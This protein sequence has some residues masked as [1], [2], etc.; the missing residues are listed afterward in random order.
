MRMWSRIQSW[1]RTVV[2]RSRMEREMDAELRFHI[3]TFAEDLV[4]NGVAREEALRRARIE[5][6]GIERAK[7]EC[8]EARGVSFFDSL[9]LDLRF[10]LRMLRKNPG[11]AAVAVI[12][13]ALGI[14]VN[15]AVFTAFDS[16]VLRPRPVKDPDSLVAVFRTAPGDARG[17]FSYPDYAYFRDHCKSLSDF[18]LFAFGIAVTSSDLPPA[19]PEATSRVAAA[20]GFQ[21]PQLLQG[22]AQPMVAMFV[23]GNYFQMLGAVPLRGRL[24]LPED[25]RPNSAPVVVMSGNFWQRQF[26]S[27]PKTVG[28]ILHLNGVAFTV[29]GVTPVDYMGTLPNVPSLWA[30]VAA[31][32]QVGS[33]SVQDF[34][35]RLMIAGMPTGKLRPGVSL[36]DAQAEFDVLA[37]QLRAAHPEEEKERGVVLLPDRNDASMLEPMEWALVAAMMSAVGLLL[38]IACA[39]VASLLL[40]RAAARRKEIA[41]RLAIGASRR[42]L[43]RQLLTE[44]LLIALFAGAIGLPLASWL[45]HLLIVEIASTLPSAWGTIALQVAPD[46]RIFSYALF[47][48]CAA[49]IAPA[50]QASKPDVNS[51]LK[52]EGTAFG[53]R[54]SRSR[55]RGLLIAS[56]MAACL[57]LLICSALLLRGSQRALKID[58]G[59]ESRHVLAMEIFSPANLHYPQARM[60]QVNRDLVGRIS[61]LSGVRSV[62]QASRNPVQ[63]LRWV[64]VAPVDAAASAPTTEAHLAVGAGY[65]F[66]TPNYF[67]TLSIPIVRGRVFTQSEAEGQSPVVVISEATAH[68]FWPGEDAIGKHLKIG[69]EKGTMFF[70]GEKDPYIPS[71]EV[72]GIARDVRSMDLRRIDESYIYLPLSQTRQWTGH[73]LARTDVDPR[74]L[75]SAVG[76]ELHAVD[77]NLPA[78]GGPLH[79]MIAMDAFFVISRVGGL[80]A[81]LVGALGLL[82]ACLGVY[83]MVSYTVAQR[84]HE[85]GVRMALGA[86]SVQV[87]RLVVREGFQPIFTGMVTGF[88]LSAGASHLMAATLFGL[89]PLD[90]ISFFG[91]S[92]LL[93]G[94]ALVATIL[95]ARRA[96]W[97]DPMV[98]LRHE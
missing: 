55:L 22:S 72:I 15:T 88:L 57:V 67:E 62:A 25:D 14:A 86:R 19:G 29:V 36:S 94:I 68:R 75:L 39:N 33:L 35:D 2:G 69:L 28:S 54:L 91:V 37:D 52:D 73:L 7:E 11:F 45:L 82:L 4:R 27:D 42:R 60:L 95:P 98:A 64:P 58:G 65:S 32:V 96:M 31:K 63:G 47:V 38:L 41:V 59:Y 40:A 10:G 85:I 74:Q 26:H 79:A 84:T 90:A 92:L 80:L 43:L 18:A 48:S 87:L 34:E 5:F 66:V 13:L 30:P 9:A 70:P 3:E 89:S 53:L 23:S 1:L 17:R 44:S 20:A 16:L 46:V 77:A 56:Q 51:A 78:V 12:T 76:R 81:S 49:G 97:V 6:G 8:R 71:S 50:L 93:G 24:L 21:L 61:G 83:G